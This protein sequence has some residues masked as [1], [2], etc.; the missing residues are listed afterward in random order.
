MYH[1]YQ[2]RVLSKK[3]KDKKVLEEQDFFPA[4]KLYCVPQVLYGNE[5]RSEVTFLFF[6]YFMQMS[7]THQ[8]I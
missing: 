7:I 4:L 5:R 3:V 6:N 8:R 2:G 1:D